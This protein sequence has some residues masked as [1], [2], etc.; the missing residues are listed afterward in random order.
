[1]LDSVVRTS[2]DKSSAGTLSDEAVDQ[3]VTV[4]VQQLNGKPDTTPN[5]TPAIPWWVWVIGGILVVVIALLAFFIIRSRRRQDEDEYEEYDEEFDEINVDDISDEKETE[6]TVR[7]KQLEK[8]AKEKP[9]DF[10]KLLRSW[11]SEE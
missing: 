9:E 6:G 5:T 2:I 3:K 7:R 10:A 4:S 1:M 11:I 8:M